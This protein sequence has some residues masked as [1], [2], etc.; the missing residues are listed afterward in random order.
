[1]RILSIFL[2]ALVLIVAPQIG[3]AETGSRGAVMDRITQKEMAALLRDAGYRAEI[4]QG[5]ESRYIRTAMSGYKVAVYFYDCTDDG[6]AALQFS[7]IFDKAPNLTIHVANSWNAQHRYA[8]AYIDTSDESI[9]FEYDFML[10]GVT[11][12]FIKD[13]LSLYETQLGNFVKEAQ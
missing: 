13:N 1:M 4:T 10:N 12:K 8:R 11:T 9:F 5:K 3:F 6:C 2:G 7:T